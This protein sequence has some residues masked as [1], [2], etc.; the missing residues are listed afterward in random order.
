MGLDLSDKTL[1]KRTIRFNEMNNLSLPF[2]IFDSFAIASLCQL[3]QLLQ[4][5]S[6]AMNKAA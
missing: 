6:Y 4:G 2:L 3:V 1:G 5:N